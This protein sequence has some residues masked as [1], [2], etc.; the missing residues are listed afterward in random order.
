[1]LRIP[2]P[3]RSSAGVRTAPPIG[4]AP[5]N[6]DTLRPKSRRPPS[7]LP[8][9]SGSCT[10][11][12]IAQSSSS[13]GRRYRHAGSNQPPVF[14]ELPRVVEPAPFLVKARIPLDRKH[15]GRTVPA[16]G[17]S[18]PSLFDPVYIEPI[19]LILGKEKRWF[20]AANGRL[21]PKPFR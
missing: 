18:A 15:I 2:P 20:V 5:C 12:H 13:S 21:K 6:R 8:R 4:G 1:M 14:P 9:N 19:A 10:M 3:H 16:R 7:S 11:I 17:F